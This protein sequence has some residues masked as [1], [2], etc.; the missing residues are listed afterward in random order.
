VTKRALPA[1]PEQLLGLVD[2]TNEQYH[3]GPGESKSR[4]DAM[5]EGPRVYWN[6]YINP[7]R[8]PREHKEA[9]DLGSATHSA[10]L[11]PDLFGTDYIVAPEF[12]L[13]T[14]QG[15]ADKAQLLADCA[16][17]GQT[18]LS[19]KHYELA[20]AMRD[21]VYAHPEASKLLG[22]MRRAGA[23]AE[24]SYYA[25]D[26]A[27]GLLVKC[28]F[29]YLAA[30]VGRAVDLKTTRDARPHKFTRSIEDYRYDVQEAFYRHVYSLAT[31]GEMLE[32]WCFLAVD[33]EPP[34]QVG[35]YSLP[36]EVIRGAHRVAMSNLQRIA[37]CKMMNHWPDPGY[38]G[39]VELPLSRWHRKSLGIDGADDDYPEDDDE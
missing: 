23:L 37:D 29:D 15:K 36:R 9:W 18:L 8:P 25:V 28:R 17:R 12:N 20:S 22:D 19:E 10:I 38:A 4:L 31:Q 33:S 1:E 14:K 6:N 13:R 34:H 30:K 35:L 27:T 32:D 2:C 24:Q 5:A 16:A 3:G 26:P 39:V 7:K 11:E 21:T